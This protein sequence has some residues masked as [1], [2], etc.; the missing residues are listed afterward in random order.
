MPFPGLMWRDLKGHLVIPHREE[1]KQDHCLNN[2][3]MKPLVRRVQSRELV[4]QVGALRWADVGSV[5]QVGPDGVKCW[6]ARSKLGDESRHPGESLGGVAPRVG[7]N[8]V[9]LVS[10]SSVHLPLPS[11]EGQLAGAPQVQQRLLSRSQSDIHL[12]CNFVFNFNLHLHFNFLFI[13]FARFYS[14][15]FQSL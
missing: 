6:P 7:G 10:Q 5:E 4:T 9:R 12:F 1:N 11:V 14:A 2:G 13:I 3:S 15:F 8:R